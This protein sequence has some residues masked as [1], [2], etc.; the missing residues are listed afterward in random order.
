MFAHLYTSPKWGLHYANVS[1]LVLYS[2]AVSKIRPTCAVSS[3]DQNDLFY[4]FI[5][6][7]GLVRRANG[8]QSSKIKNN[9][10]AFLLSCLLI[11]AS[12]SFDLLLYLLCLWHLV[13]YVS[14]NVSSLFK[15]TRRRKISLYAFERFNLTFFLP[16]CLATV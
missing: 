2:I 4:F 13:L 12:S 1:V 11:I 16:N 7:L 6:Q 3:S 8:L 10:F 9:S 15:A 14:F 5:F